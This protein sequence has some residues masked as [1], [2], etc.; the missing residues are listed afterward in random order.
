VWSRPSGADQGRFINGKTPWSKQPDHGRVSKMPISSK[1]DWSILDYIFRNKQ[2]S[3]GKLEEEF[4]KKEPGRIA[5]STLCEHLGFLR[6]DEKL[7]RREINDY[8]KPV[9]VVTAKGKEVYIA[10][11]GKHIS[12]VEDFF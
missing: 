2:V 3:F 9:Y 4:V 1:I 6:D 8:N 7:I 12:K 11:Y 10:A 5:K